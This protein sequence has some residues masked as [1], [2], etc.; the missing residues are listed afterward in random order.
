[1]EFEWDD[2]KSDQTLHERGFD[3]GYAALIFDGQTIETVDNRR[4][5]GETRIRAIG[6]IEQDVLVVVYTDRENIRRIISARKA[7]RK[8][9]LQWQSFVNP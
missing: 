6:Q 5:Y 1:M 3:F 7:S 4:L 9:R 8:E 2:T